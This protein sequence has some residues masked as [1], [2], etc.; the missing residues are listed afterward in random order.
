MLTLA[1]LDEFLHKWIDNHYNNQIS[2]EPQQSPDIHSRKF[3]STYQ[4]T[5]PDVVEPFLAPSSS[6]R[7]LTPQ[8]VKINYFYYW[9]PVFRNLELHG[10]W[11]EVRFDSENLTEVWVCIQGQWLRCFS[12]YRSM[13]KELSEIQI[14]ELSIRIRKDCYQGT[15]RARR[16]LPVFNRTLLEVLRSFPLNVQDHNNIENRCTSTPMEIFHADPD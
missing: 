4:L 10:Q 13:F 7:I 2:E 1:K 6:S 3:S 11:V 16:N 12:K 5:L 8:G 9:H 15:T 14:R